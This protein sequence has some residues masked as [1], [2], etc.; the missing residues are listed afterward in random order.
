MSDHEHAEFDANKIFVL[1]VLATA[2]EVAWGLWMP[3]PNWW[4][5]LLYTSDAADE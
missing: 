4:V 2:L 1:L 5:C 3:G